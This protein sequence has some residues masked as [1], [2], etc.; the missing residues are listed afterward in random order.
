MNQKTATWLG[1]GVLLFLVAR[2][3][4]RSIAAQFNIGRVKM[5]LKNADLNGVQFD[6]N[7]PITNP[8]PVGLPIDSFVGVVRF[9]NYPLADVLITQP[10]TI[11]SGDTKIYNLTGNVRYDQLATNIVDIITNRDFQNNL[12]LDATV[13]SA[14]IPYSFTQPINVL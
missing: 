8:L 4:G 3:Y 10:I 14:G 7:V 13:K 9:G 2:S 1:V 6:I 11:Q 12:Y 5:N